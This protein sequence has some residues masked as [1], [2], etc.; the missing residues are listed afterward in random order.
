MIYVN[1]DIST[2]LGWVSFQFLP[3]QFYLS[4]LHMGSNVNHAWISR[5]EPWVI[6]HFLLKWVKDVSFLQS[7]LMFSIL[8]THKHQNET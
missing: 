1:M 2:V 5:A 3:F 4:G 6:I 7:K 8:H